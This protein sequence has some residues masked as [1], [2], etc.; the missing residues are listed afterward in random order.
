MSPERREAIWLD[1]ALRELLVRTL[2]PD[3]LGAIAADHRATC[4]CGA[5]TNPARAD[6]SIGGLPLWWPFASRCR[7]IAA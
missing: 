4:R 7:E 3:V 2:G 5:A 6:A 1:M